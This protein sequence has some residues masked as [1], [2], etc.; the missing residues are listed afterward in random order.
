AYFNVGYMLSQPLGFIS[1]ALSVSAFPSFARRAQLGRDRVGPVLRKILRYQL[2]MA[3]PVAVGPSLMAER[4]IPFLF[5]RADFQAA[6]GAL[7]VLS[8]GLPLIFLNLTS[9]YV[10]AALDAQRSYLTAILLG[11]AVN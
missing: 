3:M 4:V 2:V 9:R 8:L 11:L 7:R 5:H 10:L 6:A 1:S